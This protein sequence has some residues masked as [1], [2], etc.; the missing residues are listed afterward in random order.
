VIPRPQ[1]RTAMAGVAR[2]V[3]GRALRTRYDRTGMPWR[4]HDQ[5]I[6]I[7][8]GVRHLVLHDPERPLFEL[9]ASHVT[10]G[11]HVLDVGA[12]LGIYAILESRL[13]GPGGRVTALE[14]TRW[15]ASI[16][17]RHIHYNAERG[18]PITLIEAAA[19]ETPGQSM[20]HEYDEAYVNALAPAVD[21]TASPRLRAVE[22]V[23][24]DDICATQSLAPTF[25]RI[26]V[27]GA[28]WHV[29]RGARETIRRA[30][31]RLIVVAEM[32]PQCWPGFGVD[33]RFGL[34]TIASLG[35]QAEPLEPGTD[36]FARDGHVV[37]TPA[38]NR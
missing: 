29:L 31:P 10:P 9:V 30:G 14:P 26:D 21:V 33:S 36:L 24:L 12:F 15:S 32:H 23:T 20:L 6:R 5:T 7:D 11:T 34:E 38:A 4:V 19:G 27:Q 28:E 8:P 2:R 17:R 25:I 1:L 37:L 22:V 3:Y 16:A 35:L 13:A 18:A